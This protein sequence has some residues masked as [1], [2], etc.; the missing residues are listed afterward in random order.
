[1]FDIHQSIYDKHGDREEGRVEEYIDGLMEAFAESPEA[2]PILEQ[3][4]GVGWAG[5]MMEMYFNYLGGE[6][7]SMTVPDFNEVVYTL[8]ARK[9][10]VEPDSAPAIIAELKAFWSFIHRQYGLNAAEKILATLDDRAVARLHKE[11]ADPSNYGM[12]KSFVM[13]GMKAGYDMSKQEDLDAYRAAYNASLLGGPLPP[14]P[15][16]FNDDFDEEPPV[17]LPAP[18]TNEQ[19]AKKRKERKRQRQARKRNRKK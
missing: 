4:G 8:F 12:A 16:D 7:P 6:L 3:A 14:M 1:M 11:L 10:S 13:G 17:S 18:L 9:V 19:R 2:Q 15:V 5:T